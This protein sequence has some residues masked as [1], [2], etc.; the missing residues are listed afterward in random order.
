M[1]KRTYA[2]VT[3]TVIL[4]I[5][6]DILQEWVDFES[7]VFETLQEDPQQRYEVLLN[8]GSGRR[9]SESERPF[10]DRFERWYLVEPDDERRRVLATDVQGKDV[11]LLADRVERLGGSGAPPAD[12]VLCKY[13][14][15]HVETSLVGPAVSE[16]LAAAAPGGG[17]GIFLAL[18][19]SEESMYQMVVPIDAF[20]RMPRKLRRAAQKSEAQASVRLDRSQF[21]DMITGDYDFP[22]IATHHFGR[23]ELRDVFPE[24]ELVGEA[25]GN[26]FLVARR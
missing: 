12:F 20:R 13:V 8:V 14:L 15:Q 6:G 2:D 24:F 26:G 3:D 4:S 22:F 1:K 21:D 11:V 7:R 23:Q 17:V 16:L 19:E 25:S 9:I 5:G 18:A 10:F